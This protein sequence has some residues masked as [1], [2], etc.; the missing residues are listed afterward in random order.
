MWT[1]K[2]A[3]EPALQL[4]KIGQKQWQSYSKGKSWFEWEWTEEFNV[5]YPFYIWDHLKN[6]GEGNPYCII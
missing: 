1:D 6:F 4:L 3:T 2:K 5:A